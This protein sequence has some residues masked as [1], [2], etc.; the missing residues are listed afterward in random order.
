MC[1]M[2]TLERQQRLAALRDTIADIERKPALAEARLRV[3]SQSGDFPVL[4]GGLV[5]EVFTDERRNGGAA[6]GFALAQARGLLN[7]QR[8]AVIYL[9]LADDA[10]KLGLPYGPGLR[11]FG[12]DP[13]A[14]VLVRPADIKEL[15]WAA[16]EAIACRAVA[17]VVADIGGHHKQM[18]FTVSRRLSLRAAAT[19]GSIFMLRYGQA[20]EASAAH[21]RWRLSPSKSGMRRFDSKAPGSHRWQVQLEKGAL[22]RNQS[23]WLLEWTENGFATRPIQ[24][25]T[26]DRVLGGASV[27]RPVPAPLGHRFSQTA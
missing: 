6:L 25:A 4:S 24:N 23:E 12:F 16:E 26:P 14:L 13:D 18:D 11:S 22:I 8:L 5:Q 15:L 27:P 2:S 19:G 1:A 10:Q 21:L 20:R 3:E 7:G 9:Q 17:A